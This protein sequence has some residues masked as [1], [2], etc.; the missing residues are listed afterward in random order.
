MITLALLLPRCQSCSF[1]FP[2]RNYELTRAV[3]IQ[4]CA[5][6]KRYQQVV[7]DAN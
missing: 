4:N 2:S 1:M 3:N 5:S 7:R 6:I